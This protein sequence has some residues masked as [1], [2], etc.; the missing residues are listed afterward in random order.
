MSSDC[1]T[2]VI[3]GKEYYRFPHVPRQ[4]NTIY[5]KLP[6]GKYKA[7]GVLKSNPTNTTTNSTRTKK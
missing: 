2:I 6:N 3:D 7:A 4:T 1:E 5:V